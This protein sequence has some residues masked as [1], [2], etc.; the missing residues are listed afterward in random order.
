MKKGKAGTKP[1][2]DGGVV[3]EEQLR[4]A[5]EG[6]SGSSGCVVLGDLNVREDEVKQLCTG[7]GLKDAVYQG[8]SWDPRRSRHDEKWQEQGQGQCYDR[9]L[10]S[11]EVC[12][13]AFL[14]GYV[15]WYCDG[16]PFGLSDHYGVLGF[17]DVDASY[18][19][20]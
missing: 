7:S 15:R 4:V 8:K 14:V 6:C 18:T 20:D 11:G 3:R 17:L 9:I 19:A 2:R 1:L 13:Q 12:V 5:R 10:F 16:Q